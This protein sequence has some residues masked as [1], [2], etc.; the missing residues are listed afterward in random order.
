[1]QRW[2]TGIERVTVI[3]GIVVWLM[4]FYVCPRVAGSSMAVLKRGYDLVTLFSKPKIVIQHFRILRFQL[5]YCLISNG[6]WLHPITGIKKVSEET[7][8]S[9]GVGVVLNLGYS[10]REVKTMAGKHFGLHAWR[11]MNKESMSTVWTPGLEVIKRTKRFGT[12]IWGKRRRRNEEGYLWRAREQNPSLAIETG[13]PLWGVLSC[14]AAEKGMKSRER[15]PQAHLNSPGS[16]LIMHQSFPWWWNIYFS[17]GKESRW[18]GI[19]N[20]MG[21][22]RWELWSG[23]EPGSG[24][25]DVDRKRFISIQVTHEWDHWELRKVERHFNRQILR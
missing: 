23:M 3:D 20:T 1:M 5:L 6:N 9:L 2:D 12:H 18:G 15:N 25:L 13:L 22:R 7:G 16:L 8:L 17:M 11:L 14:W 4:L 24:N 19:Q 21:F 10:I